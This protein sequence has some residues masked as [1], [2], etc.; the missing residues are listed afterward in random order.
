MWLFILVI[1]VFLIFAIML[2]RSSKKSEA[3]KDSFEQAKS[4]I[5]Q[6]LSK[7]RKMIFKTQN[8]IKL[9]LSDA[10]FLLSNYLQSNCN[11]TYDWNNDD[12]L[13]EFS[14]YESILAEKISA[15]E[16]QRLKTTLESFKKFIDLENKK[17]AFLQENEQKLDGM[18]EKYRELQKRYKNINLVTR[19]LEKLQK[20]AEDTSAEETLIVTN[21]NIPMIDSELQQNIIYVNE[22]DKISFEYNSN[23]NLEALDK[24]THQLD[25]LLK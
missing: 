14:K 9:A 8:N 11:I 10:K 3:H 21:E 4:D 6:N 16:L 13:Q 19:K 2:Y 7:I 22:L 12:F 1:L 18:L 17:I 5:K 23:L 24:Y 25:D 20:K 15:P